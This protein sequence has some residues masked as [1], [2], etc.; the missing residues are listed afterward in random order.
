[1]NKLMLLL[2]AVALALLAARTIFAARAPQETG[3]FV[4]VGTLLS[5][6]NLKNRK[7]R[8]PDKWSV[9]ITGDVEPEFTVEVTSLEP[10]GTELAVPGMRVEMEIRLL[11]FRKKE[12]A[13]VR[14]L[15]FGDLP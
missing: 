13:L 7:D 15:R 4:V 12:Y 1:M 11:H 10:A 14:W 6:D 2:A 8:I 3:G 5:E 9:D